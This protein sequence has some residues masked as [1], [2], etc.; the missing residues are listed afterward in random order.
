MKLKKIA[1]LALAGVMAV[2]ML[3]GCKG[4]NTPA[5]GNG[6]DENTAASIVTA[7]NNGQDIRNK[8][9]VTFTTDAALETA[10]KKAVE[11]YADGTTTADLTDAFKQYADL[12]GA[13]DSLSEFFGNED[14][15]LGYDS[16]TPAQ[17]LKFKSS[18]SDNDGD[19]VT[20]L[21]VTQIAASPASEEYILNTAA[22]TVNALVS[23]LDDTDKV[24]K[25]E[26]GKDNT[27]ASKVVTKAGDPYEDYSYTGKVCLFSVE[28]SSGVTS[29]YLVTVI[30][31]TVTAKTL[32][33]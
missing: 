33:K 20:V 12:L 1:S 30:E 11:M 4:G 17:P 8:V 24:V 7:V 14:T 18:D 26:A 2:S 32:E 28:R 29:Y 10:A 16:N 31:Q 27:G 15:V 3:A 9:K 21:R 6:A 5:G 13:K 22:D 23:Q 25:G 19:K